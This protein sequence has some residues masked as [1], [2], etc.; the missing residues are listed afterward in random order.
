MSSSRKRVGVGIVGAG[1][2]AETR[3]RCYRQVS[4]YDV[5]LVAVATRTAAS[6]EAY[7]RKYGLAHAFTDVERLLAMPEIDLVDLCVPN[8][9]HRPLAVRAAEAGKH[10]VCTKPL[11]AYVGQDLG[12]DPPDADVS[13]QARSHMFAVAVADADAMVAAADQARVQLM[14]GE[15][16]VYAPA[17]QRALELRAVSAGTIL[18]MRGGESHKG[19]HSPYS[20]RWKY[21]GGGALL[22]LGA[23]PVGAMLHAKRA[24]GLARDGR[25]IVPVAVTAEVGDLSKIPSLAAEERAYI[26]TDW[27]DVENWGTALVTFSDG[28]RATAWGADTMLGGME[29]VLE[30]QLSNARLRMNLSPNN[31]LEAYT[32][33]AGVFG[34]AYIMEKIDSGAGWTTPMPNEDWTSGHLGMCQDFVAAVA[35]GR[36]ALSTGVLGRDVVRVIYAAYVAAAEG[37]RVDLT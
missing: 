10:V 3:A 4:G 2:I 8:R 1:F 11:T 26:V 21:T 20:M 14:Y 29:S 16:W 25:P 17:V 13:R 7:A 23:H 34:D 37:R 9:V 15:N 33:E 30:F 12:A 36:P 24:E 31:L 5:D 22:R 28:S 27:V 18:D 6:A 32:P 35:D 19:S